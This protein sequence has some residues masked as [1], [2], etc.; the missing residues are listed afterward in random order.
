M[1]KESQL[2][3]LPI[4]D[5]VSCVKAMYTMY[6]VEH[7]MLFPLAIDWVPAPSFKDGAVLTDLDILSCI[8][9]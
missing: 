3:G 1:F 2:S 6:S 9:L 4:R 7:Y 8:H 5:I